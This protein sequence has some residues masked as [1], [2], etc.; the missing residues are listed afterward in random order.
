MMLSAGAVLF[1]DSKSFARTVQV[2]GEP[3]LK[4]GILSDIH[5]TDAASTGTL[6]KA[7]EYFR[8]KKVDG[9]MIA[10]DMADDGYES[11]LK[12][13]ADA[14]YDIFPDDKG[15]DG[16][17]V[18]KLFIYGNHDMNHW[19]RDKDFPSIEEAHKE[20]LIYH[21]A[22]SWKRCF[23]EEYAPI[24]L[25]TIKG[26]HFIGGHWCDAHSGDD[27][28]IDGL[29]EFF[30]ANHK[31]IAGTK[32]FFYFQHPH[33]RNTCNGPWAWGQDNGNTTEILSHYPNAIAFSGHSHCPLTDERNV[34]QGSFISIGTSSLS[35]QFPIGARENAKVDGGPR[36]HLEMD[37]IE[38]GDG[39]QGMVMY[40]YDDCIAIEKREFVYGEQIRD[41]WIIP[42]GVSD[43]P[44]S[45]ENR[46]KTAQVP[47]FG[48]D[49]RVTLT[50]GM[51]K[52]RD[53]DEHMQV[54]V[55]FPS[56]LKKTHGVRAFDYEVQVEARYIDVVQT[57]WTKHVYSP[58]C[59]LGEEHDMGEVLCVFAEREL[60]V[61]FEVRFA[62][63]PCECFGAKGRP[64]YS[65][66]IPS[67]SVTE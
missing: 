9:V 60:P 51:G 61:N 17:K 26:Y 49:D 63:R 7:F 50:R 33:P 24:Y 25:K 65:E 8:E 28:Q 14:W 34:W 20:R 6:R 5:I 36:E 29:A 67:R 57:G 41:N 2:K 37:E 43:A 53:G 11:E 32:P 40:V 47:Q 44:M 58:G 39:R 46:A 64:I 1:R 38:T 55:H 19:D 12:N 42:L 66:W 62:V 59:Y 48:P 13:V 21:R 16:G 10:G 3:N 4:I 22:E 31:K 23:H 18:E 52:D 56:V 30:G 15:I 54:T 45:Y 35:Y 27:D